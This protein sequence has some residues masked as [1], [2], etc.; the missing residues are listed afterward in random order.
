MSLNGFENDNESEDVMTASLRRMLCHR[1]RHRG[2]TCTPPRGRKPATSAN[3]REYRQSSLSYREDRYRGDRYREV[4]YRL[5][6]KYLWNQYL[7]N[8]YIGPL[9]I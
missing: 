3:Y 5:V 1:L 8:Q 7:W 4:R 2:C 9:P 6:S